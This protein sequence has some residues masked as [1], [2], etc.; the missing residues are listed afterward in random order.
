MAEKNKINYYDWARQYE[1]DAEKCANIARD[2]LEKAKQAWKITDKK[3][4]KEEAH[5]YDGLSREL[6][7]TARMIRE[8]TQR[9]GHEGPDL[10]DESDNKYEF[11]NRDL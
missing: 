1:K 9:G 6:R 7:S 5:I 10:S 11:I 4:Y 3:K 2:K 8:R